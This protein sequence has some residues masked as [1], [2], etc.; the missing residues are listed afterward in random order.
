MLLETGSIPPSV[1]TIELGGEALNNGLVR[2]LYNA[3][4]Q[5]V[6]NV[7]GP[8]ECTNECL[9]AVMP[10]EPEDAAPVPIGRPLTNMEAFVVNGDME[11]IV[12]PR[13]TASAAE[14][15]CGLHLGSGGIHVRRGRTSGRA[16]AA[17][18]DDDHSMGGGGGGGGA[19]SVDAATGELLVGGVGVALGYLRRPELS[20]AKF[21]P[22]PFGV[23]MVYRTGD[24]VR[25]LPSGELE[26]IGRIDTQVW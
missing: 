3:G 16:T 14:R 24:R 25:V 13:A 7:Y 18:D 2:M 17:A 20:A 11:L 23:G 12:A 10:P 1:T 22:N 6:V 5:R 8:T 4:V 26:F 9:T 21:I 15:G 19:R